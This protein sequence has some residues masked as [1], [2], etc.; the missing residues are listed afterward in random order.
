MT[1]RWLTRVTGWGLIVL[2][3]LMP[4]HAIA[5]I[6]LGHWFGHQTIWAS[7][8][9]V[10]LVLL[11]LLTIIIT[12]TDPTKRNR[13]R[14]PLVYVLAAFGV[15]TIVV[16]LLT[17]PGL[18]SAAYGAKTD[19]EF[20]LAAVIAL[21]VATQ[22][23]VKK[24]V[25]TLL[26]STGAVIIFG[27]LQ[28]TVLPHD[29][30]VHLGYSF[31]PGQTAPY[32]LVVSGTV[33]HYRFG[34]TLG[35]PNQLGTFLILPLTLTLLLGR[36]RRLWWIYSAAILP[37]MF[38]TYSRGAWIGAVVAVAVT[39]IMSAPTKRRLPI[40]LALAAGAVVVGAVAVFGP[41]GNFLTNYLRHPSTTTSVKSSDS[42]HVASLGNGLHSVFATPLGHGLGT[43]G[44]AT[45]RT[46]PSINIIEN[47][48]L[49]IGYE[50][51]L[52]GTVLFMTVIGLMSYLLVAR[53]NNQ[54]SLATGAALI[55]ISVT[56]LVLPAFT[57][58]STALTVFSLAGASLGARYV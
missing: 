58:S 47:N 28:A 37:V 15:L 45:F 35:G 23:L 39:L 57:D 46:G 13:L 44:P 30:L 34:S 4:L 22:E 52:M 11:S 10:L 24:L 48:Y 7:W 19:L 21:I 14:Q 55:G 12:I 26:I 38:I 29:T 54:T 20:L 42:Q 9:E 49:Q 3:A 50:A 6:S 27:L 32:E 17:R 36:K 2:V 41:T 16:T 53:P 8:K 33:T 1:S 40:G 51:G 31:T 43:A 25:V 5:V 18:H 56:A